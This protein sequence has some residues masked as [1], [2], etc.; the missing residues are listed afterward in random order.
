MVPIERDGDIMKAG[1]RFTS[2]DCTGTGYINSLIPNKSVIR[3]GTD[4]FYVPKDASTVNGL[5]YQS[6]L[7]SDTGECIIDMQTGEKNVPVVQNDSS[8]TGVIQTSFTPPIT[9]E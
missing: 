7:N 9:I 4:I 1:V 2:T 3:S 8:I 5:E 6:R